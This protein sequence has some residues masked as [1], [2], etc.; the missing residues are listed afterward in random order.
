MVVI[1]VMKMMMTQ[2]MVVMIVMMMRICWFFFFFLKV[3]SDY[4]SSRPLCDAVTTLWHAV[5]GMRRGYAM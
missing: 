1:M 4:T 5:E 3:L 2:M